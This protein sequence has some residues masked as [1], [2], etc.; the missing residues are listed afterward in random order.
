MHPEQSYPCHEF[1]DKLLD[2]RKL[3]YFLHSNFA[4]MATLFSFISHYCARQGNEWLIK[5]GHRS[6]LLWLDMTMF[7]LKIFLF[8]ED[9]EFKESV[10]NN[11][12]KREQKEF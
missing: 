8:E 4:K 11:R 5:G 7:H 2:K 10:W 3:R 9:D 1:Q 6:Y 12:V